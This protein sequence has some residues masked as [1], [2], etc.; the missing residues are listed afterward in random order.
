MEEAR[1]N[2]LLR[3]LPRETAPWGFTDQVLRRLDEKPRTAGNL[4]RR[5][6]RPQRWHRLMVATATVGALGV[7]VGISV[8]VLQRERSPMP[9]SALTALAPNLAPAASPPSPEQMARMTQATA[10][11]PAAAGI[12]AASMDRTFRH[13]SGAGE[14]QALG[15]GTAPRNASN[16]PGAVALA[17][18][19][20]AR[21]IAPAQA[22]Q[23]LRELQLE[24]GRLER[25]LHSLRRPGG[26]GLPTVLYL[27]GDENVDLVLNTGRTHPPG[28]PSGE[29]DDGEN[30][31]YL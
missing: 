20:A 9:L 31:N 16:R 29:R 6:Q 19:A 1:L 8:G 3:G 26:G 5:T 11:G 23:L 25:E 21:A 2:H 10:A 24:S 13:E 15:E 18:P 28:P 14:L 4:T 22:Y 30:F 7:S 27:G 12:A 17:T